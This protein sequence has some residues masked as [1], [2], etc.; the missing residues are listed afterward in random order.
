MK[1]LLDSKSEKLSELKN[2][3]KEASERLI[4]VE[5]AN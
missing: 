4:A 3:L 2:D 5:K 1:E